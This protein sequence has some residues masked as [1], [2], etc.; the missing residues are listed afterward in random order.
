MQA[1]A[2]TERALASDYVEVELVAVEAAPFAPGWKADGLYEYEQD[3][4]L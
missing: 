2:I 4:Y 3:K 1:E